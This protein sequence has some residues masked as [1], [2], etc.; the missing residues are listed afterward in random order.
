MLEEYKLANPNE[1]DV[2]PSSESC[3]DDIVDN[4]IDSI[5]ELSCPE[6]QPSNQQTLKSNT[7]VT[8]PGEYIS[9]LLIAFCTSELLSL[10]CRQP[11]C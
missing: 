5:E 4:D 10:A 11:K 8:R 6:W 3:D 1:L 7:P 2:N 9:C